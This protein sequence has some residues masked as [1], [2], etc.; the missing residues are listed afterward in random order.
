MLNKLRATDQKR[1]FVSGITH[2]SN[3]QRGLVMGKWGGLGNHRYQ[4]G[5]SGDVPGTDWSN[6]A[7]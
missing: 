5:D 2:D 1:R 6:L 7:F 3:F 4:V